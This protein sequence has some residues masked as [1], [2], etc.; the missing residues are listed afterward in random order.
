MGLL[1]VSVMVKSAVQGPIPASTEGMEWGSGAWAKAGVRSSARRR[2]FIEGHYKRTGT[3]GCLKNRHHRAPGLIGSFAPQK[4]SSHRMTRVPKV[5]VWLALRV[6]VTNVH[7]CL[8]KVH[9][10]IFERHPYL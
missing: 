9:L 10:I 8:T 5:L 4:Q 1:S 7:C 3:A 2:V 6:R